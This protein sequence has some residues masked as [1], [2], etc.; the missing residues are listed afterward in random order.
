MHEV[1]ICE[2]VISSAQRKMIQKLKLNTSYEEYRC[3]LS[4]KLQKTKRKQW[5]GSKPQTDPDAF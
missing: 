1:E 3:T 2:G 4:V 5:K